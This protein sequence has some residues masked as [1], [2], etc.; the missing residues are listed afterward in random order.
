MVKL[1]ELEIQKEKLEI[2]K[3]IIQIWIEIIALI[4][5]AVALI[6]TTLAQFGIV[7]HEKLSEALTPITKTNYFLIIWYLILIAL[8]IFLVYRLVKRKRVK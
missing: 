2:E 3:G 4:G 6:I 5:S 1:K 7:K 8:I